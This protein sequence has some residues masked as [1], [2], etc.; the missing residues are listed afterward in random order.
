M[1][2]TAAVIRLAEISVLDKDDKQLVKRFLSAEK[3]RRP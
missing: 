2:A 1:S 3:I